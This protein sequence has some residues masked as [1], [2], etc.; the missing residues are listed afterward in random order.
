MRK[1]LFVALL[2]L[3]FAAGL[4]SVDARHSTFCLDD[5]VCYAKCLEQRW[6]EFLRGS[7]DV[8]TCYNGQS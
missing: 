3:A 5:P 2:V 8:R 4:P 7:G 6:L 1:A